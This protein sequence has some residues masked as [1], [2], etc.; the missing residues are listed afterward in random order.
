M[1]LAPETSEGTRGHGYYPVLGIIIVSPDHATSEFWN[2]KL[3]EPHSSAQEIRG[4]S[5]RDVEV[6]TRREVWR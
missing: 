1:D 4:T 3:G 2:E 5:D 6:L